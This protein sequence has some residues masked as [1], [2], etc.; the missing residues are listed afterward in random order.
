M[1]FRDARNCGSDAPPVAT[2]RRVFEYHL[3]ASAGEML[4]L[5]GYAAPGREGAGTGVRCQHC[6][7]APEVKLL[8]P[9]DDRWLRAFSLAHG[10]A[11]RFIQPRW[12]LPRPHEEGSP[13]DMNW[14]G[15]SPI[16]TSIGN[17]ALFA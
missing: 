4:E 15:P 1:R 17:G 14:A 10:Q 6:S 3:A 16:A 9:G 11:P 7:C 5:D 8:W 12:I 2:H 13:M